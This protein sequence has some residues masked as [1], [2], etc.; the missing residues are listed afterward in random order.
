L[1]EPLVRAL[2]RYGYDNASDPVFIQSFEVANLKKLSRMTKLPLVQLI[3]ATGKPWDFVANNDPRTY[4]DL[5]KPAGLVEIAKYATAIGAN[6][7][8]I[9]PRTPTDFLGTPTML[10]K[11]AHQAGLIVHAWTFRAENTFLPK[12]FRSSSDPNAFGDLASEIKRYLELGM[13]GFFTDQ[14]NIGVRARDEFVGH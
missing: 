1:E 4:A 10:V 11:D 7:N 8:L 12:D 5:V 2:N 6:K 14:S 13:D 9:I 3:D